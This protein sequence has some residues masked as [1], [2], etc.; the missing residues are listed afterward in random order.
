MRDFHYI[1]MKFYIIFPVQLSPVPVVAHV[2]SKVLGLAPV[3]VSGLAGQP[4][5]TE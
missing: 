5:V 3:D 4:R 2:V 1:Y